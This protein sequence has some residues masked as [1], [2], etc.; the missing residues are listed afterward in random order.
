MISKSTWLHLRIPFS[1]F[2]M[3]VYIFSVS[4]SESRNL[5][6][7]L[8]IF[9]AL[10]LFIYPASNGFN[11]FYDKDEKSIGGL[12][13]PPKVDKNLLSVSLIFDF[14][15][16]LIGLLVSIKFALFVYGLISKA[17]SHPV[18]R[19]KKYP[20]G[21]LVTVGIFQ[22][23]FI[24]FACI[25][26][27][28]NSSWSELNHWSII[29]PAFIS[30]ILLIGS[31]PMTQI[32]QHEEDAKRGDMS[33]SLLLGI[34]GTFIFTGITFFLADLLFGLYF[35]N[36]GEI[37]NFFVLQ[38]FLTP[39]LIF[40]N[41]WMYKSWNNEEEVNF[42]RTMFLNKV[43]SIAMILFFLFLIYQKFQNS[44]Q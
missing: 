34:R 43:S 2:L 15:G 11:S 22:G 29:L 33:L 28:D 30:S 25:Q 3:P 8:L 13:Y 1:I 42:D 38:G 5:Y 26:A 18:I 24:Y 32:Y 4:Q 6:I 44:F 41:W 12:K 40:F 14:I 19:L 36:K 27:I 16:I 31:Y 21:G 37:E 7:P 10:H 17:Y 20:I 23:A 9:F 35:I 39:V